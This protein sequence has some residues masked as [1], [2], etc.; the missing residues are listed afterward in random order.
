MINVE[1]PPPELLLLGGTQLGMAGQKVGSGAL[2]F[3]RLQLHN[4]VDSNNIVV[5]TKVM[6]WT[7]EAQQLRNEVSDFVG[8]NLLGIDRQRDTRNGIIPPPVARFRSTFSAVTATAAIISVTLGAGERFTLEDKNGL[9]IL[10]PGTSYEWGSSIINT[11][12]EVNY[13]WRERPAE[14][15]ELQF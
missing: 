15:S 8:A 11:T 7:L 12:I 1:D 9:A 5:V 2:N 3:T 13:F 6:L 14:P 4:P 10:G